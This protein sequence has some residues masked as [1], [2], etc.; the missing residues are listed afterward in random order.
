MFRRALDP[1]RDALRLPLQRGALL[2]DARHPIA[3]DMIFLDESRSVVGVVAMPLL[4]RIPL[5]LWA[6]PRGT[7]SRSERAKAAAHAV[8][9]GT[10]AVF[11]DVPE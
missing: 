9:P 8:G 10:R 5:A 3:L 7:W 2:L 11:I 6:S 1:T 4:G